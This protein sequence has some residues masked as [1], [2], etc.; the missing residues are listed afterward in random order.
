MNGMAAEVLQ[1]IWPFCCPKNP[2]SPLAQVK[3][4]IREW[5]GLLRPLYLDL[6]QTF[7][8]LGKIIIDGDSLVHLIV[9]KV[10]AQSDCL[11]DLAHF[12]SLNVAY[13]LEKFVQLVGKINNEEICLVFFSQLV[14][15]YANKE[16]LT[17]RSCIEAHLK[18]LVARIDSAE[19]KIN[20][21]VLH[22]ENWWSDEGWK[23]FLASQRISFILAG[24]GEYSKIC[25]KK[26]EC[27]HSAVSALFLKS[28]SSLGFHSASLNECLSV[29]TNK[30]YAFC[31]IPRIDEDALQKDELDLLSSIHAGPSLNDEIFEGPL[32]RKT[33]YG[34]IMNELQDAPNLN[35]F[36][37]AM[38]QCAQ[39]MDSLLLN[40]RCFKFT[41]TEEDVSRNRQFFNE[42]SAF[43]K[44]FFSGLVKLIQSNYL[45]IKFEHF[46]DLFDANLYLKNVLQLAASNSLVQIDLVINTES[47]TNNEQFLISSENV[48]CRFLDRNEHLS[49]ISCIDYE[50]G[51]KEQLINVPYDNPAFLKEYKYSYEDLLLERE[52]ER[53]FSK[54][55][56]VDERM[57]AKIR[58]NIQKHARFLIK[59]TESLEGSKGLHRTIVT[60][61]TSVPVEG[62]AQSKDK[63]VSAKAQKII[64]EN[65]NRQLQI[66]KEK[67]SKNIDGIIEYMRQLKTTPEQIGYLESINLGNFSFDLT[68]KIYS[69]KLDLL[70]YAWKENNYDFDN[71]TISALDYEKLTTILYYCIEFFQLFCLVAPED[72]IKQKPIATLVALN[73]KDLVMNL[74]NDCVTDGKKKSTFLKFISEVPLNKKLSNPLSTIRYQLKHGGPYFPRNLNSKP[75]PRVLFNPDG[76]QVDLLNI[77]DKGESAFICAPTASGK[78]FISYY[79]MEKVLRADDEGIVV[80]VAPTKPLITQVQAEIFAR[81]QSKTYPL[82]SSQVLCGVLA[83]DFNENPFNCQVLVTIPQIF[84]I[85]L[86]SP[87]L[88]SWI[89]KIRYVVLDEIHMINEEEFGSSWER[90][91]QL[92]DCPLLAMSA[93]IENRMHFF[94]WIQRVQKTK[95][96]DC[97]LIQHFERYSDLKKYFYL[98][99]RLGHS[100]EPE[101]IRS[102]SKPVSNVVSNN[103]VNIHPLATIT[104][105]DIRVKGITEDLIFL[106]EESLELYEA[107]KTLNI[108]APIEHLNPDE[109]FVAGKLLSKMDAR[110][111]ERAL[112]DFLIS[113]IQ[114]KV[115]SLD[116]FTALKEKLCGKYDSTA[117]ALIKDCPHGNVGSESFLLQHFIQ[118]AIDLKASGKLPGL[119]FCVD[120]REFC[121]EIAAHLIGFLNQAEQRKKASI[122][123]KLDKLKISKAEKTLK[124]LKKARDTAKVTKDSWI[125]EAIQ[126]EEV[127]DSLSDVE[128]VDP[129]FSFTE[130][131][132][133]LSRKEMDEIINEIRWKMGPGQAILLEGLRRGI[134]VHHTGLPKKYLRQVEFLFRKK[135]LQIVISSQTLALGIN[136]PCKS[137]VFVGGDSVHLN[138]V[139]F[140]Q[141]SGRAGRRGFDD[142]GH[143]I[144]YGTTPKKI[145]KLL[146]SRL[147]RIVGSAPFNTS[148]TLSTMT[149]VNY[150][151]LQ[152]E[153][154]KRKIK[155]FQTIVKLPL[156]ILDSPD[157]SEMFGAFQIRFLADFLLRN[158]F[159]NFN[160][161]VS[162]LSRLALSIG[163]DPKNFLLIFLLAN[164]VFDR[165]I[166]EEREIDLLCE[167]IIFVLAH[168]FQVRYVSK[169]IAKA[170]I[171]IRSTNPE[172]LRSRHQSQVVLQPL[173]PYIH[174]LV[175]KFNQLILNSFENCLNLFQ[176]ARASKPPTS[177]SLPLCTSV[178]FL[179]TEG[180]GGG[181]FSASLSPF[182][183]ISQ[184][185][186]G[187]GSGNVSYA[188][189]TFHLQEGLCASTESIPACDVDLN[190]FCNSYILDYYKHG[191]VKTIESING[192]PEGDL[193]LSLDSF[194]RTLKFCVSFM[195]DY[196]ECFPKETAT[197]FELV[198]ERFD[199]RFHEMYA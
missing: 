66:Q 189:L 15:L 46:V 186:S 126:N 82:Y 69:V 122:S 52:E 37:E 161:N 167:Q 114:T 116:L 93:T 99:P 136:M 140:R 103:I 12:Q 163:N 155:S 38:F 137:A 40:E 185:S 86:E 135:H 92:L 199:T 109:F 184:R 57:A 196:P 47:P 164:G 21:R 22:F 182:Y 7:S 18:L 118:L 28:I 147:P 72:V 90:I 131:R 187:L 97:H 113:S 166:R 141:M 74:I 142:I 150:E 35:L 194:V 32:D 51:I 16:H 130:P 192:V 78:T 83:R 179:A 20:V 98:P 108:S 13:L 158:S 110:S 100:M 152:V 87:E 138:S 84:Q 191:H 183:L 107:L 61:E 75:D 120:R 3:M 146:S 129:D 139:Q 67:D 124:A 172:L 24:D 180:E 53:N 9:S 26:P 81:F 134:G 128:E 112:K 64:Q 76:W 31:I 79:A 178:K 117:Q 198:T 173:P 56:Q 5:L 62:A 10:T 45:N 55:G 188:D 39:Q 14:G 36:K 71:K 165:I 132:Y 80:F 29:K 148:L 127:L 1:N 157:Y 159:I 94:S 44:E 41:L 58:R 153:D 125:D 49:E 91:I 95:G 195:K 23:E 43:L 174:K 143:V 4:T 42:L 102:V 193:W 2:S 121:N 48:L 73:F 70:L 154:L 17:Y 33:C 101:E 88:T 115:L 151:G 170:F 68:W 96:I 177:L 54:K 106:P 77:V 123:D 59:Y 11:A 156:T 169:S 34:L 175:V 19:S 171:S 25:W 181:G 50:T 63:K 6:N 133:K 65:I 27:D 162:I 119:F 30:I 89:K 149:F 104:Y 197:M 176:T 60:G 168:F 111:Y 85:L 105:D 160:G 8:G 145:S 144:F 190:Q